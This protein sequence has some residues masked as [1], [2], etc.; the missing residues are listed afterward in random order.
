[1][2]LTVLLAMAQAECPDPE[3]SERTDCSR[4]DD[5]ILILGERV[6][7]T[8]DETASSVV[9]FD[10]D[11]L[12]D[13]LAYG[14]DQLLPLVPN[15]QPGSGEEG[16]AIRGQDSTGPLRN[17]F[18]FLGGTRPRVTLQIDGR[19]AT[20]YEYVGST[21]SMWDLERV[22]I[23]RSPQTTTQ[24][25]NAIAGA[26]FI[27][28]ADPT[29]AFEGRARAL[30]ADP[31]VRQFS[32]AIS[33]PLS[34]DQIAFRASGDLR[35]DRVSSDMADGIE[36]AD[37]DRD[38]Y[39]TARIKLLFDPAA[40]PGFDAVVNYTHL[41]SQSPQF[42]A[43]RAPFRERVSPQL[44]RTVGIHR[45]DADSVTVR[46]NY[47]PAGPVSVALTA[48]AGDVDV[49]RFALAGLGQTQVD[50]DD[51][52]VETIVRWVTANGPALLFGA[53]LMR[54]RLDQFIDISRLGLGSG[55]FVDRQSS[56]GLFSEADVAISSRLTLTA[57]A[58][59]QRD[60][61]RREGQVGSPPAGLMLDYDRSFDAWLPKLTLAYDLAP[62]FTTGVMIQRAYNPGGTTISLRT[63]REDSF[64]AERLW[65]GELFVRRGFGGRFSLAANL[66]YNDIENAQR[67]LLIPITLPDGSPFQALEFSNAP[68]AV[69]WGAEAELAWMPLPEVAV[70]GAVGF[71]RTE[72]KEAVI[73]SDATI[74][75][76]FQR[77]PR[78]SS[79]LALD[80]TPTR[81]L[82]L[83]LQARH[84]SG[85]FSDDANREDLRVDGATIV[86]ARASWTR[87]STT[88]SA[89][90]RNLFDSFA[91]TYLFQPDFGTAQD[92][93]ELGIGLETRF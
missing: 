26:I 90:A 15:I 75:K 74:G 20:Y 85:Y 56:I 33:G 83:S 47:R 34:G 72:L 8:M 60:T 89:Y 12:D 32:A 19:P 67:Q 9:A 40:F 84:H 30:V 46:A 18:A 55:N 92:P 82:A 43:V 31:A 71:L 21:A 27:E 58:R 53:H 14:L 78:F 11:A 69:S 4:P 25:R 35:L 29:F 49:R 41:R 57:G 59:Y 62:D 91:M 70:R 76:E 13:S 51:R 64:E 23:F 87:G 16:A 17:L 42:E 37:I 81:A 80:W 1:M 3:A 22:E 24:G 88:F 28:T 45:I 65:N 5:E 73:L 39:G 36:G 10:A 63:G 2:F 79:A 68:R 93:R 44:E 52:S 50:S 61:Q 86:D 6:A 38:D 48:S 7:R 54:I 66:F 77:A